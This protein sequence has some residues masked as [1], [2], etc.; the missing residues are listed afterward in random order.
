MPIGSLCLSG[1]LRGPLIYVYN[2]PPLSRVRSGWATKTYAGSLF[3]CLPPRPAGLRRQC[4]SRCGSGG[5]APRLGRQPD[6]LHPGRAVLSQAYTLFGLVYDSMC[7]GWSWTAA[8]P[9]LACHWQA[10]DGAAPGPLP[11]APVLSFTMAGRS[12][13][14]TWFSYNFYKDQPDFPLLGT[15]PG[16]WNRS[17]PRRQHGGAAARAGPRHPE[18]VG[19]LYVLP[20]HVW[21]HAQDS[22]S[23]T[24]DDRQRP[25][26]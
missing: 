11:C 22:H 21:A 17:A 15:S 4:A 16:S 23:P 25:F 9:I 3:L 24:R 10:S 26:R 13:P 6:A 7:S 20:E 2:C 1:G 12:L 14:G 8:T 18:P 5:A 19:F